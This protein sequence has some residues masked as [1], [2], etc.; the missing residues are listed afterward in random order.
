MNR[1]K[2]LMTAVTTSLMLSGPFSG[3]GATPAC[4]QAAAQ[5]DDSWKTD[6]AVQK[7][8]ADINLWTM[9]RKDTCYYDETT[10]RI[11]RTK[12]EALKQEEIVKAFP[13]YDPALVQSALKYL[14]YHGDIK[15][16]GDGSSGDP[17]CY[18]RDSSHG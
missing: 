4:S 13:N 18:C 1:T 14:V 7:A 16:M 5:P 11:N 17:F 2:K 8:S 6:P 12:T 3:I 15:Q 9:R 10:A